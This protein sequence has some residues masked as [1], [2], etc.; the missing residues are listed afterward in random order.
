MSPLL[1]QGLRG[2]PP[3]EIIGFVGNLI[4]QSRQLSDEPDEVFTR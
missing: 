3:R 2:G 4:E 1:E